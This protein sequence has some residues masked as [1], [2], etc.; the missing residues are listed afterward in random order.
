M[1]KK[2]G[3]QLTRGTRT[4]VKTNLAAREGT[5]EQWIDSIES[6]VRNN[7]DNNYQLQQKIKSPY[8]KVRG[9]KITK[10]PK[11][12]VS[13]RL[14]GVDTEDESD[15]ED[16]KGRWDSSAS[17]SADA[18]SYSIK[19]KRSGGRTNLTSPSELSRVSTAPPTPRVPRDLPEEEE[20]DDDDDEQFPAEDHDNDNG[21][22]IENALL[23]QEDVYDRRASEEEVVAEQATSKAHFEKSDL[24]MHDDDFG[25]G[26]DDD[27]SDEGDPLAPPEADDSSDDEDQASNTDAK[28]AAR[29][30]NESNIDGLESDHDDYDDDHDDGP[31]Y[32]LVHDPETPETVRASRAK[33]EKAKFTQREAKKKKRKSESDTETETSD[34]R[35]TPKPKTGKNAKNN[36]R[37][38]GFSPQGIPISNRDYRIIPIGAFVESSPVKEGGPRRSR[39]ARV[40]P[41]EY[42]RGEKMQFGAHDEEGDLGEVMGDMP[43]VKVIQKA[44]PTPYKKKQE[45]TKANRGNKK[46]KDDS[47]KSTA[48]EEEFD[49][50][51]LR[52]KYKY[53]DGEEAYLWDDSNVDSGDQSKCL[54]TTYPRLQDPKTHFCFSSP[55]RSFPTHPKWKEAT[56]L[57]L[58]IEK[59]QRGK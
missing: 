59:N 14:P 22:D 23:T 13:M 20:E 33:K 17:A 4:G 40:K 1:P 38:V 51:K 7:D 49:S 34:N 56:Y 27:E 35:K 37:R 47:S 10:S 54:E 46:N 41:L 26:G 6:P 39:R 42:W 24:Q 8:S 28:A 2:R 45:P 21:S 9:T 32:N 58:I 15:L 50:R 44:N 12:H 5:I 53:I 30:S 52:R 16:R 31:G 25:T 43:V 57:Y 19:L 18:K 11:Q 55:Q 36:K 29:K 3:H 48:E